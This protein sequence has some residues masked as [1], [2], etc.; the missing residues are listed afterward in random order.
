M[1]DV[2]RKYKFKYNSILTTHEGV[3]DGFREVLIRFQADKSEVEKIL[4]DLKSNYDNVELT[5][6]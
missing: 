1:M 2:M 5:I 6:D 3:K 4:K